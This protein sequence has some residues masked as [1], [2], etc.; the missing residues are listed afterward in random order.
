MQ[1]PQRLGRCKL[2]GAN[3]TLPTWDGS[4][5]REHYCQC[6]DYGSYDI[7]SYDIR[8]HNIRSCDIRSYDIR[9]CADSTSG[10]MI[11][12]MCPF[13]SFS[14]TNDSGTCT[15]L[16][17][18]APITR[19]VVVFSV[20]GYYLFVTRHSDGWILVVLL[21]PSTGPVVWPRRGVST[22]FWC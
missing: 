18:Y 13:F 11:N 19:R 3:S 2:P 7:R 14:Y 16:S 5:W 4:C 22:P 10:T 12:D 17:R 6:S 9:S 15:Y 1:L 8:S 20:D 21:N